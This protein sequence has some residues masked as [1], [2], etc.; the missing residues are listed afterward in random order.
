[1]EWF[2][3][4]CLADFLPAR[5]AAGSP[6]PTE[7]RLRVLRQVCVLRCVHMRVCLHVHRACRHFICAHAL[8]SPCWRYLV[9]PCHT[10]S[11]VAARSM[12]RPPPPP[13]HLH[14][15]QVVEGMSALAK[16]RVIHRD[17]AAR[18]ILLSNASSTLMVE[19]K[20]ADFGL[21]RCVATRG[22]CTCAHTRTHVGHPAKP[23]HAGVLPRLSHTRAAACASA[24][25]FLRA[26]RAHARQQPRSCASPC[27]PTASAPGPVTG[28]WVCGCVGRRAGC[29]TRTTG[30]CLRSPG[31]TRRPS[32]CQTAATAA[33]APTCGPSAC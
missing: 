17:L 29:R 16:K 33:P 28:V 27:A 18:N 14:R 13:P 12:P 3:D 6:L 4:G 24:K 22:A 7:W 20:I 31:G 23:T 19:A 21:S 11:V 30:S 2:A 10:D 26:A 15:P 32:A 25:S 5:A 1:M 8:H 9:L